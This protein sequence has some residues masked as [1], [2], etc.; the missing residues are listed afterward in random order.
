MN[1]LD[2]LVVA[3]GSVFVLMI[4]V[5]KTDLE[6]TKVPVKIRIKK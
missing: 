4:F 1:Y 6:K 2:F 3:V 5:A